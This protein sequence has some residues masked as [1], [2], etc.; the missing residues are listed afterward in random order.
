MAPQGKSLTQ[1][2]KF[3]LKIRGRYLLLFIIKKI[4]EKFHAMQCKKKRFI[5]FKDAQI[6]NTYMYTYSSR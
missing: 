5:E 2:L 4:F 1:G 3:F 6:V